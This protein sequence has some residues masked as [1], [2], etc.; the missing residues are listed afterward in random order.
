ML[1]DI[2]GAEP[3]VF[4]GAQKFLSSDLPYIVMEYTAAVWKHEQK[5]LEWIYEHFRV[6]EMVYKPYLIEAI[7]KDVLKADAKGKNAV[8]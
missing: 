7:S 4:K 5:L 3:L 2:E 1:M 6:F 8:S